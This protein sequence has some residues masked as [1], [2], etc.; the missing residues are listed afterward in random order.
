MDKQPECYWIETL[1]RWMGKRA[2]K[3]LLDRDPQKMDGQMSRLKVLSD[4]DPQ[5]MDNKS[6][7]GSRPSMDGWTNEQTESV[8]G[9]RLSMDGQTDRVM[10]DRDP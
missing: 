9:S 4:R 8:I 3:V 6:D 2:D 10:L 5:W 7:I 1:N